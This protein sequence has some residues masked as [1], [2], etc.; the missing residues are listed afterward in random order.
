MSVETVGC[1]MMECIQDRQNVSIN[2][3]LYRPLAKLQAFQNVE[4][5]GAS[6]QH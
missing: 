4:L 3:L 1:L 6:V 2:I 5:V